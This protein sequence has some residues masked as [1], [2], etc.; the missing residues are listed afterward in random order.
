MRRGGSVGTGPPCPVNPEHGRLVDVPM[1]S[2]RWYCPHADHV[3]QAP[4][5][6]PIYAAVFIY[7]GDKL[8]AAYPS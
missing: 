8:V 2:G 5:D 6:K 7:E 4:K 1:G 3:T